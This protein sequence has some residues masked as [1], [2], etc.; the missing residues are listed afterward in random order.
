MTIKDVNYLDIH[1]PDDKEWKLL[2][3]EP[4]VE[5]ICID[6]LEGVPENFIKKLKSIKDKPLKGKTIQN[7]NKLADSIVELLIKD[8]ISIID[9]DRRFKQV[10]QNLSNFSDEN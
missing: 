7:F 1:K 9:R 6:D 8:K 10:Q 5:I 4:N 2:R 3:N